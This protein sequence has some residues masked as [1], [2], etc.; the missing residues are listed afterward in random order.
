MISSTQYLKDD[1]RLREY[2]RTDMWVVYQSPSDYPGKFVARHI[3]RGSHV[4]WWNSYI[5]L[6]PTPQR[7]IAEN[8]DALRKHMPGGRGCFPPPADSDP[9]IV[10]C[11]I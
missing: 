11:W 3:E 1:P 10:E 7:F 8:L 2:Q 6:V 4:K 9:C 5:E